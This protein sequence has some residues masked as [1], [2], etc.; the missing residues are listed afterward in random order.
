[1]H[2]IILFIRLSAQIVTD[3]YPKQFEH[4]TQLYMC[5]A[6]LFHSILYYVLFYMLC[7]IKE[8]ILL[9]TVQEQSYFH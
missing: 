6:V 2:C 1:M 9:T 5:Y 8:L 3:T 4:L 7:C